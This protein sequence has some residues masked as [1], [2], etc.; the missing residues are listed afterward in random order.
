MIDPTCDSYGWVMGYD[1]WNGPQFG[2]GAELDR[3]LRK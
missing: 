1:S 3:L 2:C